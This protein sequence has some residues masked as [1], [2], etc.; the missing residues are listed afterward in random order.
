[1][2]VYNIYNGSELEVTAHMCLCGQVYPSGLQ[3][4]VVA[5]RGPGWQASKQASKQAS[6]VGRIEPPT[7]SSFP[8]RNP[9]TKAQKIS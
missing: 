5:Q 6:T 8:G 2:C 4:V 9:G 1:M 3:R 7:V